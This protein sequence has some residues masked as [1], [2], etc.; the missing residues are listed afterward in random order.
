[1]VPD[2]DPGDEVIEG[3]GYVWEENN[4]SHNS[5]PRC[6]PF[7]PPPDTFQGSRTRILRQSAQA[8]TS[9]GHG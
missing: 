4:V 9:L 1:M 2:K 6:R 7:S 5:A 8:E 3:L